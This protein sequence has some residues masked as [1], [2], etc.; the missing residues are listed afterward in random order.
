ME[1]RHTLKLTAQKAMSIK[2]Q[3]TFSVELI[4][5]RMLGFVE[6]ISQTAFL[7]S[8]AASD[9]LMSI[10]KLARDLRTV[11]LDIQVFHLF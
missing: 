1:S 5:K 11:I 6:V 10:A 9:I 7:R 2:Q 8:N 4:Q 3:I